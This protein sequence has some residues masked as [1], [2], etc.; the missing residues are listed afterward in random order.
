MK[1][2]FSTLLVCALLGTASVSFSAGDAKSLGDSPAA[3]AAAAWLEAFNRNSQPALDRVITD[4]F[5]DDVPR[6]Q[7]LRNWNGLREDTATLTPVRVVRETHGEFVVLARDA[8]GESVEVGFQLSNAQP[9]RIMGIRVEPVEEAAREPADTSPLTEAQAIAAITHLAD[10]LSGAERFSGVVRVERAGRVALERA[11]GQADRE[12]HVPNRVDT[13]FNLGSIN[14]SFTRAL[15]AKLVE[16]GKIAP[17]DRLSKYLP[18]FPR[19]KAD[20]ITIQQL[21][22]FR[23]GL[24]DFFGRKYVEMDKSKLRDQ[25]DWF[26]L[27]VDDPLL[28]EPGQGQQYSNAGYVVLGA[29]AEAAAGRNY[30]DLVRE[31]VYRPAGMTST[32]SYSKDDRN[33]GYAIGYTRDRGGPRSANGPLSSNSGG[34]PWRGSAA[35]GGYSTAQDLSRYLAALRQGKIL[36]AGTAERFFGAK[37]NPDGT[38]GIGLGIAGGS[39]G[40]N[41]VLLTSGEWTVI[42]LANLDPPSAESLGTRARAL[43]ER[44]H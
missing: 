39:P 10:S 5:T 13:K 14:K 1:S 29:V 12:R 18:D 23:S 19:E 38:L 8:H 9:P 25:R 42:V 41:G 26:P 16:Q 35:G 24:G 27:F 37:R 30:Y 31:L 7:R 17:D 4:H 43:L 34:Q 6:A 32:D 21:L 3:R 40:V 15:I 33:A 2:W 28:Y 20:R 36:A 11:W 22:D 44:V